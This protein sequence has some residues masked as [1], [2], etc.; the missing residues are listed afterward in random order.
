MTLHQVVVGQV[1]GRVLYLDNRP[2][3]FPYKYMLIDRTVQRDS[4]DSISHESL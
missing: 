4:C 1:N 2:G 3:V